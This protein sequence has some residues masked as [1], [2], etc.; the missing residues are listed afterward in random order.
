MNFKEGEMEFIKQFLTKNLNI[1]HELG[2][3]EDED[4][5]NPIV[6]IH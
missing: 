2:K 6:H 3:P 4:F 5:I 1:K